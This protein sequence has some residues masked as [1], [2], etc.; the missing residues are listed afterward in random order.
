VIR[1]LARAS[2]V[3]LA[4][5]LVSRL[6]GLVRNAV[7]LSYFG[8][9]REY[10]AFLS[11]IAIPDLV[12]QVLAG[13]AVGS[14][15]IPVFKRYVS[16]HE[17]AEAWRLVNTV[18]AVAA[19]GVGIAAVALVFLARPLTELVVPGR[20]AAFKDLVAHL[21]RMMLVSPVLF[22]LSGFV[23]SVLHSYQ[24]FGWAALA[25]V[26]YNLGI[27][28]SAV[29]LHSTLG[30]DAAAIG[31]VLG[32][33]LHLLIQIPIAR[34]HGL[35]WSAGFDPRHPGVR[36]VAGLFAPRM[37]GL[38]VVQINQ[39]INVILASF[40]VVGSLSALNVSWMVLMA[41]LV[42]AMAVGTAMFP[43]LAEAGAEDRRDQLRDLFSLALRMILF[44]T[45]P[46]SLGI[47]VLARPVVRILFERGEFT[48]A[49][50]EM[51]AFALSLYA[52]GLAGHATVEIAD[53]V[54]YALH[55]TAT[56]VR[57]AV[58]TVAL[59]ILLSLALMQTPLSYGGLALANSVAALL[60]AG[61]L[62]W[63]LSARLRG[64]EVERGPGRLARSLAGFLAAG[65]PMG[66]TSYLVLHV[67]AA[68]LDTSRL[69]AQ[70]LLVAAVGAVGAFVY[71]SLS[72]AFGSEE[73]STLLRLVRPRRRAA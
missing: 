34:Q 39:L 21:T 9:S 32:A 44:I 68:A 69:G 58:G 72:A 64:G 73:L 51:T 30:I 6:L 2:L 66:A 40:L 11:A 36:E 70:V 41:P 22:A 55:D 23:T 50:T 63:L 49:S 46:M 61:I 38:G 8:T 45:V 3:V 43:T 25:P 29:A 27:I 19:I 31:V 13:G 47:M 56:P 37:L 10:D 67:L 14:A 35:R 24:R 17:E 33:A 60:E 62:A 28:V 26:S 57:V 59:N 15:F 12:F 1:A 48:A 54:F 18:L 42:L 52:L 7:L 53:R 71:L 4:G 5:F 65:L 20:D 16:R